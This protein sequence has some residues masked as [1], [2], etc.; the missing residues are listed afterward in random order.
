MTKRVTEVL[1]HPR[2][3][4]LTALDKIIAHENSLL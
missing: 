4:P 3:R 2:R 1:A